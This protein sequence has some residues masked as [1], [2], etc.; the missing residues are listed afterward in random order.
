M[1]EDVD[2]D[3]NDEN[4]TMMEEEEGATT[5]VAVTDMSYTTIS[6]HT[7]PVYSVDCD[8]DSTKQQGLAMIVSG[9]GDDRAYLH[10]I[11]AGN[12]TATTTKLLAHAH[13]DSVSSV[14]SNVKYVSNDLKKTP[15]LIAVGAY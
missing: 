9:G 1:D 2:D 4:E 13:T 10:T 5:N 7:G 11:T 3:G 15:R 8:L 12:Q 6:S 14:A